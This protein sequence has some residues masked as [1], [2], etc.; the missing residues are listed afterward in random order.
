MNKFKYVFIIAAGLSADPALA[1]QPLAFSPDPESVK[2]GYRGVDTSDIILQ[3]VS[4]SMDRADLQAAFDGVIDHYSSDQAMADY[5]RGICSNVQIIF[6]AAQAMPMDET[7][8][9]L[10]SQKDV[11]AFS[12]DLR[13]FDVDEMRSKIGKRTNI[14]SALRVAQRV[15]Q[16][17]ENQGLMVA[18]RRV[19]AISDGQ[20][21]S[22]ADIRALSKDLTEL[23][24]ASVSAITVNN[25][26]LIPFFDRALTTSDEMA[27][28]YG[29]LKG[30]TWA[31]NDSVS[32]QQ[33]VRTVLAFTQG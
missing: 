3:D 14:V 4:A 6:Y 2:S 1:E 31:A 16:E 27:V 29:I 22:V 26:S 33:G 10:C 28:A 11:Q 9:R 13:E 7:N 5:S 15:Y 17:E 21:G 24:S 8:R 32:V 19:V 23:F 18:Q 25:D 30:T 20:G 12:D